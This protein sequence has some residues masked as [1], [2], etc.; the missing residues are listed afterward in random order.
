[1]L[2]L[3][4]SHSLREAPFYVALNCIQSEQNHRARVFR[5]HRFCYPKLILTKEL[6][7]L[8]EERASDSPHYLHGPKYVL[9]CVIPVVCLNYRKGVNFCQK[10]QL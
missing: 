2:V 3:R 7:E 6:A 10:T 8:T 9:R 5:R 1:M 4:K